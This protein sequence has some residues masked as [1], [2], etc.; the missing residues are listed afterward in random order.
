M[1][2]RLDE[3]HNDGAGVLVFLASAV[4][5]IKVRRMRW[6]DMQHARKNTGVPTRSWLV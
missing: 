1:S 4:R 3:L 6:V 2:G 5:S